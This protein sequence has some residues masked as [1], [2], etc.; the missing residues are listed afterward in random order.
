MI[1]ATLLSSVLHIIF[2]MCL[3][4]MEWCAVSDDLQLW[5]G[6]TGALTVW[7]SIVFC[8]LTF[9][10]MFEL[11]VTLVV[12]FP[13][14][15]FTEAS[16]GCQ[17][18]STFFRVCKRTLIWLSIFFFTVSPTVF[19]EVIVSRLYRD[20]DSSAYEWGFGQI[21]ALASTIFM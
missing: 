21:M 18:N 9:Q 12:M 17:Y 4:Q 8:Q 7:K 10:L 6:A 15:G 11:T 2:I 14:A 5:S 3:L 16:T 20:D 1:F 19:L 13:K